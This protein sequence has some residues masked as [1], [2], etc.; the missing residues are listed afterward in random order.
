MNVKV[1]LPGVVVLPR[2]TVVVLEQVFA[3]QDGTYGALAVFNKTEHIRFEFAGQK[4]PEETMVPE[5][6]GKNYVVDYCHVTFEGQQASTLIHAREIRVG[7][8]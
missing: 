4:P 1:V 3:R 8:H 6:S 5:L 2:Q 7:A